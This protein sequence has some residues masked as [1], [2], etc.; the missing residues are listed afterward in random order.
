M[1][2]KQGWRIVMNNFIKKILRIKK[3]LKFIIEECIFFYT[4]GDL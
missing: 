1:A 3:V 2:D 4:R